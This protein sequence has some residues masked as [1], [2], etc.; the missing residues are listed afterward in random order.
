MMVLMSHLSLEQLDFFTDQT[1]RAVRR[2][3]KRTRNQALVGY[4]ILLVGVFG[5]YWNGQHVS[6]TERGAIVESGRAAVIDGCNR[7]FKATQRYRGL[8]QRAEATVAVQVK[9][10][11]ITVDQAQ[12]A[13]DFYDGE[14]KLAPL[15][16]CRKVEFLPTDDPSA[17]IKSPAPLHP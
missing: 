7:D 2:A 9:Q 15:P 13:R 12:E 17:P 10:G 14:L 11:K 8:L 1:E 5:M 16:D 4:L 6:N 3:T